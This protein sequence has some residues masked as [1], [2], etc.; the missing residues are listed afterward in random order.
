MYVSHDRYKYDYLTP[1]KLYEV[2]S[3]CVNEVGNVVMHI[4]DDD[5]ERCHILKEGCAHLDGGNWT[6]H[7]EKI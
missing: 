4:T 3:H 2:E 5:G 7:K 6:I 1:G